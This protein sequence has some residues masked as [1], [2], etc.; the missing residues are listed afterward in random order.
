MG[1]GPRGTLETLLIAEIR[2]MRGDLADLYQ[3]RALARQVLDAAATAGCDDI[4][5]ARR[6][7]HAIREAKP[8]WT[9]GAALQ[10]IQSL[11]PKLSMITLQSIGSELP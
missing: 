5:Q 4:K 11:K 1:V 2:A 9:T 7:L 3:L 8:S 6:A 10:L